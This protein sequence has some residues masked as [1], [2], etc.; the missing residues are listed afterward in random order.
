MTVL[1]DAAAV[2]PTTP[3]VYLFLGP[4]R[5][6]LYVGKAGNLRRRL[7]QHAKAEPHPKAGRRARTSGEVREV[8]WEE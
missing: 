2:A 8:V 4:A 6:L 3:G 5:E 1:A 7:Q